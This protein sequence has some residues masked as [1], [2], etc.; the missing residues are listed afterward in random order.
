MR[1]LMSIL[2]RDKTL[3]AANGLLPYLSDRCRTASYRAAACRAALRD[4]V[5]LTANTAAAVR[6]VIFQ[7]AAV[8]S[9]AVWAASLP[10]HADDTHTPG[11]PAPVFNLPLGLPTLLE[12]RTT[13]TLAPGLRHHRIVRR[14]HTNGTS[15]KDP[16]YTHENCTH[17]WAAASPVLHT[18]TD[19]RTALACVPGHFPAPDIRRFLTPGDPGRSYGIVYAGTFETRDVALAA[20]ARAPLAGCG[21]SAI[22]TA[23]TPHHAMGP[24]VVN[25]L[26]VDPRHF[27]GRLVS[28]LAGKT[29]AGPAPVSAIAAD[30][31]ALAAVNGGFFVTSEEDGVIGEP[32]GL[33]IVDSRVLSEA[34]ANRPALGVRNTPR[35]QAAIAVASAEPVLHW[36]DGRESPIDGINRHPGI[37]RNCGNRGDR[38]GRMPAHDKTCRDDDEIIVLTHDAGFDVPNGQDHRLL[39]GADGRLAPAAPPAPGELLVIATGRHAAEVRALAAA[40]DRAVINTDALLG[41]IF[42][43]LWTAPANRGAGS[44]YA[45]GGGPLLLK[46]GMRVHHEGIEG[47]HMDADMPAERAMLVHRWFN[48]RTPRTAAGIT[49]DGRLLLVTVDGRQPGHSVGATIPEMRGM[50]KALGAVDAI[51]LDGGGSTAM[52]IGDTLVTRPSDSDGERPVGEA[53]L[54]LPR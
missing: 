53:L 42:P 37:I 50:M 11:T 26:E 40:N 14:P 31:R 7:A 44:L 52:V 16:D 45:V 39:I 28:A 34:T 38:E 17:A 4:I 46:N 23:L 6:A 27:R 15:G 9:V 21:F 43:D 5:I 20:I 10:A 8:F 24:W 54:L 12:T 3:P 36:G 29:V 51:N 22:H 49:R 32:A 1:T 47:W 19:E 41:D 18:A 25:V 48:I 30:R 33:S 13:E 35:L 2:G